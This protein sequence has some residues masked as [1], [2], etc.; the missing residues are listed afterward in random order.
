MVRELLSSPC[1]FCATIAFAFVAYGLGRSIYDMMGKRWS[2]AT[3]AKRLS[4]IEEKLDR[5]VIP[6]KTTI[7]RGKLRLVHSVPD[8]SKKRPKPPTDSGPPGAA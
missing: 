1:W 5:Q 3:I 8:K 2:L 7:R 6:P 4:R